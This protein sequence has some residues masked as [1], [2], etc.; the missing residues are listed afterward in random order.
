M[1]TEA[2]SWAFLM[3]CKGE[4]FRQSL[5]EN[6]PSCGDGAQYPHDGVRAQHPCSHLLICGSCYHC[7]LAANL[8][9]DLLLRCQACCMEKTEG[10]EGAVLSALSYFM[11][12]RSSR[13][14]P[15]RRQ[16]RPCRSFNDGNLDWVNGL[17][18]NFICGC[19]SLVCKSPLAS[20]HCKM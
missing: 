5:K 1:P 2:A 16:W 13:C 10:C 14:G 8:P 4:S 9:L 6:P 17:D 18:P 15:C 7:G 20:S 11:G 12:H 3:V 19:L